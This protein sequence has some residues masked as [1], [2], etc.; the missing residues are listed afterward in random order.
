MI[1]ITYRIDPRLCNFATIF[2]GCTE[3]Q[4]YKV[5]IFISKKQ[6]NSS[7]ERKILNRMI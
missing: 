3:R 4:K 6:G 2:S 5:K 7:A 1:N